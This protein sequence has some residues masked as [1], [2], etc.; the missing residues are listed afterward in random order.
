MW[1]DEVYRLLPSV[2]VQDIKLLESRND[3]INEAKVVVC[4]YKT[5]TIKE[6]FQKL[7]SKRFNV[8]LFDESQN[9]KNHKSQQ[10]I[11]GTKLGEKATRVVLISGTPALSRPAELFPQLAI[12][13]PKFADYFSFTKRYCLG[14]KNSFGWNANG[15]SNLEELNFI[16]TRSFMIRRLKSEVSD[17]GNKTR[18]VI[19]LNRLKLDSD[20]SKE[21]KE[22]A[23][24]YQRSTLGNKKDGKEILIHWFNKTAALKADAVW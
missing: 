2:N 15:S 11:N 6:T 19:E 13:D 10:S 20:A 8:I 9:L 18:Q 3:R 22:F 21:M 16:L 7:E 4:S 24:R 14:H 1:V 12:I 5:L 17:L 23:S